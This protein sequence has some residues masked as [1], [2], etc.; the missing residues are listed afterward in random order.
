MLYVFRIRTERLT[1]LF[2]VQNQCKVNFRQF[3]TQHHT[4]RRHGKFSQNRKCQY[5]KA[6]C[7]RLGWNALSWV[8][9]CLPQPWR[10]GFHI[11]AKFLLVTTLKT[12][13]DLLRQH[14]IFGHGKMRRVVLYCWGFVVFGEPC[15]VSMLKNSSP[16]TD[17]AHNF[18][19]G[20]I[21]LLLHKV[22]WTIWYNIKGN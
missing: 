8:V 13:F 3:P 16:F 4:L 10:H 5:L 2:G 9:G 22:Y 18:L 7:S 17:L 6:S 14:Y 21:A 20:E 1:R 19:Y 12:I 15:T 11:H